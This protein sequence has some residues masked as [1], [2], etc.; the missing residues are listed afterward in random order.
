M[1]EN[2]DLLL[3]SDSQ[4]EHR[5]CMQKTELA[6]YLTNDKDFVSICMNFHKT[7]HLDSVG[8]RK[9]L[10]KAYHSTDCFV[11]ITDVIEVCLD[12]LQTTYLDIDA[13]QMFQSLVK[14]YD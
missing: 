2:V 6:D 8:L 10:V 13:M 7:E 3:G 14:R 1:Q 11:S 4:D 12:L 9:I 5:Q